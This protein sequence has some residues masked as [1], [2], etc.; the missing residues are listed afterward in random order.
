MSE[1]GTRSVCKHSSLK[2]S[3]CIFLVYNGICIP[4]NTIQ[5]HICTT[6]LFCSLM[7]AVRV[8]CRGLHLPFCMQ[9]QEATSTFVCNYNWLIHQH[10]LVGSCSH[11]CSAHVLWVS[12]SL[13]HVQYGQTP[14]LTAAAMGY[15]EVASFLLDNGSNILELADV[16]DHELLDTSY[17]WTPSCS[18]LWEPI[19]STECHLL[20]L[21]RFVCTHDSHECTYSIPT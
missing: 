6:V 9:L 20:K 11:H 10:C 16:S 12:I 5:C 14:F 18:L 13:P 3:F 21:T 1:T 2:W 4:W 19:A 15:V 7:T 8:N 17:K